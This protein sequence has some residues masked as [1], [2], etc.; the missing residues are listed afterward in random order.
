MGRIRKLWISMIFAVSLFCIP[1]SADDTQAD[2]VIE[3]VAVNMPDI[4]VYYRSTMPAGTPEAYLS[5]KKLSFLDNTS[6]MDTGEGISYYILLDVSASISETSFAVVKD[7]LNQFQWKLREQDQMVLLTFGDQVTAFLQGTE[8][9]Q[10]REQVIQGLSN[11]DQNTVLFSAISDA[12]TRI[13]QA[14][15]DD[16]RRKLIL[17]ITD[18]IDDSAASATF[19]EAKSQ[20]IQKGIPVY[21]LVVDNQGETTAARDLAVDTGGIMITTAGAQAVEK[22]QTLQDV[23][24]SAYCAHFRAANNIA[25]YQQEDFTLKFPELNGIIRSKKI[26]PNRSQP[27]TEAPVINKIEKAAPNEIGITYS[28]EVSGA[29]QAS[30]YKVVFQG[31]SI[32]VQQVTYDPDIPCTIRLIFE[33]DLENGDY[34]VT[35]QNIKDTSM[36]EN[37]LQTVQQRLSVTEATVPTAA[38]AP[39]PTAEPSPAPREKMDWKDALFTYW[40]VIAGAAAVILAGGI[41]VLLKKKKETSEE[42]THTDTVSDTLQEAVKKELPV[43]LYLKS[44]DGQTKELQV[45]IMD[46]CIIGRSESCNVIFDDPNMSRQHFRLE[47]EEQELYIVDLDTRNGTFVN[48]EPVKSRRR[49]LTNDTVQAGNIW[50]IIMW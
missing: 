23:I 25:S 22:L 10:D 15:A 14:P 2:A 41:L 43:T 28:E 4:T 42:K 47:R 34:D 1:V 38:E 49:L 48:G 19:S 32:P 33:K 7:S 45:Q 20:L 12:T 5:G 27:D 36:E 35:I 50:M 21:M 46:T 30:N 9:A 40:Y 18:G 24:Y 11:R 13:E 6:F 26:I 3:Q 31:K 16:F 8:G 37:P 44:P 17:V 39:E 29:D